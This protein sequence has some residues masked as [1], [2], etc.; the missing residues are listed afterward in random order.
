MPF[1]IC[2]P[3]GDTATAEAVDTIAQAVERRDALWGGSWGG[4]ALVIVDAES[5]EV[6]R[7]CI[8]CRGRGI[9]YG[10]GDADPLACEACKGTGESGRSAW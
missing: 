5:R 8:D 7:P 10:A 9:P 1:L 3:G 2:V 4:Q 6:V